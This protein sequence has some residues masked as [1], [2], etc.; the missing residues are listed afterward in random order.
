MSDAS[1]EHAA[2]ESALE[3]VRGHALQ[4]ESLNERID[5]LMPWKCAV[6]SVNLGANTPQDCD[7][8]FCGCSPEATHAL[9]VA[10]ESGALMPNEANA[11][12]AERDALRKALESVWAAI[13]DALCSGNGIEKEYAWAVQREIDAALKPSGSRLNA[14]R[15]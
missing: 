3:R 7:Y 12:R 11:L 15:R 9:G 4:I 5:R 1:S 10:G 8:P 6:R 14:S 2:L 13:G